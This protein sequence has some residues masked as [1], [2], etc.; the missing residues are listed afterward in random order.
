MVPST[1]A[2]GGAPYGRGGG[3]VSVMPVWIQSVGRFSRATNLY[4][5]P[6]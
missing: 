6:R 1:G 2:F 3:K 4:R 5:S